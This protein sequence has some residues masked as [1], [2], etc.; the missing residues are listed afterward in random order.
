[1]NKMKESMMNS[2]ENLQPKIIQK[3]NCPINATMAQNEVY[4]KKQE[5]T[6]K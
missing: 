2:P 3:F 6:N 5:Y 4:F 1:M